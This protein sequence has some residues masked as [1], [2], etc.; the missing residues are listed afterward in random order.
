MNKPETLIAERGA[1]SVPR[2][3]S[4]ALVR[5]PVPLGDRTAYLDLPRNLT[6]ADVE[7]LRGV[8]ISLVPPNERSE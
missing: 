4:A 8:M 1:D 2:P 6:L 3:C 7:R 5:Y